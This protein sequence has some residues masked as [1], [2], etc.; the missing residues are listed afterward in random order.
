MAKQGAYAVEHVI[1]DFANL[2]KAFCDLERVKILGRLQ[3]R[4]IYVGETADASD[5]LVSAVSYRLRVSPG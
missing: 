4:K 1:T 5:I 3:L 2:F